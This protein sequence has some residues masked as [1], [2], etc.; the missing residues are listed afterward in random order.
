MGTYRCAPC[1]V[2]R[3]PRLKVSKDALDDMMDEIRMMSRL[4]HPNVVQFLAC[5]FD[6]FVCL[7][8]E[9]AVNGSL[10]DLLR[11]KEFA[12][13]WN[14]HAAMVLGVARGL[15]YLHSFDLPIIHRDIKPANVRAHLRTATPFAGVAL[16]TA[17][18]HRSSSPRAWCASWAT[19]A[20]RRT[21]A[22]RR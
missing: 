17:R 10:R 12:F 15:N 1:A 19:L 8:L 3:V 9:L 20:S 5:C 16:L 2:K 11:S 21:C 14:S 22:S 4:H 6:P 7:V 13:A 18:F